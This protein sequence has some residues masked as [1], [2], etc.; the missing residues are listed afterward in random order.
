MPAFNNL[1]AASYNNNPP[2]QTL[3]IN[4][5]GNLVARSALST[6]ASTNSS[7]VIP[8][9]HYTFDSHALLTA[10]NMQGLT[11]SFNMTITTANN[12]GGSSGATNTTIP[13]FN[14]DIFGRYPLNG[15]HGRPGA[16]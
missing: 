9:S 13:L 15:S 1:S 5:Q 11:P 10:A 4:S 6:E 12:T 14:N 7:I 3:G 2:T 16:K 8:Q